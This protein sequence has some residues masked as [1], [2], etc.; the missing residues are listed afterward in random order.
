ME[1]KSYQSYDSAEEQESGFNYRAIID[2][3]ILNW[4]WFVLS[5]VVCVVAVG[6]TIEARASASLPVIPNTLV[7][8]VE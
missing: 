1:N 6:A 5:L 2:A 7:R 3:V 4:Y 8:P